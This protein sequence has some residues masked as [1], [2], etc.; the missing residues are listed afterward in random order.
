MD[1]GEELKKYIHLTITLKE[2]E[3]DCPL[4]FVATHV[5]GWIPHLY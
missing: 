4:S 5:T 2:Q 1:I 3:P